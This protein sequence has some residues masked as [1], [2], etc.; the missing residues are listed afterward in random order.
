MRQFNITGTCFPE[1][2]YMVDISRQ[3]E[4]ACVL[5]RDRKYFTINRGR[6]YGKTTTLSEL[7]KALNKEG[8]SV[9][10]ISFE[11][12]SDNNFSSLEKLLGI[13]LWQMA[14]LTEAEIVNGLSDDAKNILGKF[15]TDNVEEIAVP[16]FNLIVDKLCRINKNIVIIIDEVDQAGN[17]TSFIKFL[18]V[19][20]DRYLAQAKFPTF[21]SVILAGVYDIKNLKLKIRPDEEHQYNSPWNIAMAYESDMSLPTDGIAKMLSEYKADHDI[22]FNENI[23][24]QEI[25]AWTSGYPFLVSRLCMLIDSKNLGWDKEGVNSAI[26]LI[27]QE[28]NTLFDDLTKKLDDF[29]ELNEILRQI[30]MNGEIIN[31]SSGV[32]F[33]K[34]ANLF[35]Y[36]IIKGNSIS[37]SNRIIE[38]YLYEMF[39]TE[40]KI[41]NFYSIGYSDKPQFIKEDGSLNLPKVLEKFTEH[42]NKIYSPDD[43]AFVE[44]QGR[45]LFLLYLRPIINGVGNYYVEAETRDR[46]RTDIVIDYKSKQYVIEL[47]IWHG[48][49]YNNKGEIQLANYLDYFNL[50]EGYMVSFCFNKN[51]KPGLQ[52]VEF[53][54]KVLWEAVV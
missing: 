21:Q 33:L 20:R 47:K 27:L 1:E 22:D 16:K 54:E 26:K 38:T 19:L 11:G 25:H 2:H 6:Q 24:A 51:K 14:R 8:F 10:S 5:V 18:G 23:V 42:F 12:L 46:T 50:Q 49:E 41:S 31:Y 13:V 37:I 32:K 15:F 52:K 29:P 7:E 9:F 40:A 17:Y 39:L 45:K 4:D 35:G 28:S 44:N 3:V 48:E 30:L 43:E 36:I 53:G 34:L